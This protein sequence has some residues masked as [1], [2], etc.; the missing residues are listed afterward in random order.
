M[1][2]TYY[3][4]HDYNSRND[5]KIKKLVSKHGYLGY[6]LF[7][8]IIEDLYNNANALQTDY[9]SIAFDLRTSENII[10]S[11]I[12]DFDLFVIEADNFGSLSV[13]RRLEERDAKSL[14]A[15]E[16]AYKRWNKDKENANA[17]QTDSECNAIK[18]SKVNEIKVN[19]IKNTCFTFELFWELYDKKV[20]SKKC[21]DKFEKVK[22]SDRQKILETLPLYVKSTPDKQYRKNPITYLNNESWN[23][24]IVITESKSEPINRLKV[25]DYPPGYV[26]KTNMQRMEEYLL[27]TQEANKLK[28]LKMQNN[29][30]QY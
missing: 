24:T 12:N 1:K 13:Q 29:E 27:E 16:S 10:E 28:E 5:H 17:L 14:K 23:D 2:D 4:S 20:D 26:H 6:G 8:A 21:K 18:E 15:R 25:N 9:E 3:F 30:P 19:E 7:W 22:E 11:I